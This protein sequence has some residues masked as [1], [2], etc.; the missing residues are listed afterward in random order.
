MLTLRVTQR[1]SFAAEIAALQSQAETWVERMVAVS[2]NVVQ[3]GTPHDYGNL[4]SWLEQTS[5]VQKYGMRVVGSVGPKTGLGI[6]EKVAGAG[7]IK[8][9]VKWYTERFGERPAYKGAKT[10]WWGLNE[11]QRTLLHNARNRG[12]F[13]GPNFPP[14]Y[15][16]AIEAG[17]VPGTSKNVGF[18]RRI[19]SQVTASFNATK[20]GR[21]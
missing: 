21:I 8:N 11:E 16:G 14:K 7:H 13:G 1:P 2:V 15:Y 10:A 19:R 12:L 6:D 9:F 17:K 18:M 4:L 20:F 5:G 3:E